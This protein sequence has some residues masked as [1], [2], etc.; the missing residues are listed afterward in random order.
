MCFAQPLWLNAS[1]HS[2]L[3]KYGSNSSPLFDPLNVKRDNETSDDIVD[4]SP[5]KI[6]DLEELLLLSQSNIVA[7][8]VPLAKT[9]EEQLGVCDPCAKGKQL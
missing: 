5:L 3:L 7:V 8:M 6:F 2:L 1:H 4:S 9:V